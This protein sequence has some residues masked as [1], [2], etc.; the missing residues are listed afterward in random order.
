MGKK[1]VIVGDIKQ[2]VE[3]AAV[4]NVKTGRLY[5]ALL[6]I[7]VPRL[8]PTHHTAAQSCGTVNPSRP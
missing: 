8:K 3:N 5:Q 6:D 1:V 4:P 2:P 7:L